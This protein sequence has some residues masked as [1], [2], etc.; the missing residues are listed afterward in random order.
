[1]ENSIVQAIVD[2][3]HKWQDVQ[4]V[5]RCCGYNQ[6]RGWLADPPYDGPH[7]P[8]GT[9]AAELD[10]PALPCRQQLLDVVYD[11]FMVIGTFGLSLAATQLVA[12]LSTIALMWS[13]CGKDAVM[14][15]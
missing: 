7:C 6:S 13:C 5:F 11:R 12:I 4:E 14:A 1:M 8:N 9:R 2:S 10:S 3:P 15:V